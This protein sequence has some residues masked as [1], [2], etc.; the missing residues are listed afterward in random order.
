M[1]T[2]DIKLSQLK[3]IFFLHEKGLSAGIVDNKLYGY[4]L[5]HADIRI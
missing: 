1:L 3:D 4:F 2:Y 5:C